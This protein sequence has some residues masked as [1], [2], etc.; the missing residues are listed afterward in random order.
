LR[1]RFYT[2]GITSLSTGYAILRGLLEP[3]AFVWRECPHACGF[4]LGAMLASCAWLA[5]VLVVFY[6]Y[7]AAT[8]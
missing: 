1:S 3:F 4:I 2:V 6:R 5:L 8:T 7:I